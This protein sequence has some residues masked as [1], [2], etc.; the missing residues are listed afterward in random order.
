MKI[1]MVRAITNVIP[2]K[3]DSVILNFT[4]NDFGRHDG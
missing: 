1:N 3:E 4:T 2:G